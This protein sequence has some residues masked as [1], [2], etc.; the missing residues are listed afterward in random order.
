MA[1]GKRPAGH[2]C[3]YVTLVPHQ[4]H[5]PVTPQHCHTPQTTMGHSPQRTSLPT[6]AT[7][8]SGA[9]NPPGA[10]ST[11]ANTLAGAGALSQ[12]HLVPVLSPMS[13]S[14]PLRQA[15]RGL[16][17][18]AAAQPPLPPFAP[19]PAALACEQ[20]MENSC[21]NPAFRHQKPRWVSQTNKHTIGLKKR[22]KI[23]KWNKLCIFF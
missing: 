18:G 22:C 13:A 1:E 6:D 2:G 7:A 5:H 12:S 15:R 21:L 19:Q 16:S 20:H 11:P 9:R 4:Q 14:S 8:H 3:P 17:A 23:N 10:P